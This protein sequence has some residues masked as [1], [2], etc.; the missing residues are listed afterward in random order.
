MFTLIDRSMAAIEFATFFCAVCF[1]AWASESWKAA[2][3]LILGALV[4]FF[5]KAA[6]NQSTFQNFDITKLDQWTPLTWGVFG[7]VLGA[8][9]GASLRLLKSP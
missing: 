7:A 6:I 1:F 2:M 3:G 8:V 4:I 9:C 5:L